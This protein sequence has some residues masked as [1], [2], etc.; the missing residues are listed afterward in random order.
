MGTIGIDLSEGS[1]AGC[2]YDDKGNARAAVEILNEIARTG[3]EA[4]RPGAKLHPMY[5]Y[6]DS[7]GTPITAGARAR[8]LQPMF[9]LNTVYSFLELIDKPYADNFVQARKD[10]LDLAGHYKICD[11]QGMAKICVGHKKVAPEDAVA[12]VIADVL[13]DVL[14]DDAR[15]IDQVVV[16]VP[17]HLTT[18]Q[19]IKV[20]SAIVQAIENV[21]ANYDPG[22]VTMPEGEGLREKIEIVPATAAAFFAYAPLRGYDKITICQ[23]IMVYDHG[24]SRMEVS[25]CSAFPGF[26]GEKALTLQTMKADGDY[27]VGGN[28]IDREIALHIRERLEETGVVVDPQ[29]GRAHV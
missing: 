20:M 1:A 24:A 3:A 15:T 9:A 29:I 28:E 21:R 27:N 7:A 18:P 25:I 19:T 8:A 6:Y 17:P 11:D 22:R 16:A 5:V 26:V 4:R 10:R 2:Y 13:N 23:P 14:E 12:E